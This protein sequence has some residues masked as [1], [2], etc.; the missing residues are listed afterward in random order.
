M[1]E[2]VSGSEHEDIV[3]TRRATSGLRAIIAIHSTLLGPSLGGARFYPYGDET[4]ALH[5]VLRLSRAMTAKAALAGLDHGGGKAVIIGDPSVVKTRSLMRDFAATVN[6][7]NGRYIT[8]EDVGTTQQDMDLIHETT[9]FVAGTSAS[10]GGSGDPSPATA[11]GVVAAMEAAAFRR[12]GTGL[13]GKTVLVLG[14]GKV[15]GHVI[16]LLVQRRAV[17]IASDLNRDKVEDAV[18]A[19]AARTVDPSDALG[20][21]ADILCPCGLGGILTQDAVADLN[22]EIIVGGANNQLAT[23]EV[24]GTLAAG[25]TLYIPDFLANAGGIINIAEEANGY[26]HARALRAVGRIRETTRTVLGH[27]E[28]RGVTPLAA[29]EDLVAERLGSARRPTPSQTH[30]ESR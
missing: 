19:G 5:D 30:T 29:A 17:V 26:D 12:W 4:L 20:T 6:G 7:L 3:I 18:R 1:F 24:A 11:V 16:R 15:G 25:G 21:P 8:A 2:D 28:A 23:P 10:R 22:F 13:E 27:A 9:P 14:A